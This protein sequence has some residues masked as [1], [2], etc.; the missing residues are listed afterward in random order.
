MYRLSVLVCILA[1]WSTT[2]WSRKFDF[3]DDTFGFAN[4]T[5]YDYKQLSDTQ[6]QI[7]RRHG[8]VP[9]FSRHC[10]HLC[11]AVLQFFQFAEFRPDLPKVSSSDYALIVRKVS[12]IPAWSSGPKAKIVVPGYK[13]LHDFSLGQT[14][15]DTTQPR[16]LVAV[17]LETR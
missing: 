2:A 5:Y 4:Q 14:A 8:R 9:D 3:H 1:L 10:F 11:R 6:I 17:L 13:D 7:S 15:G 16:S 12:A